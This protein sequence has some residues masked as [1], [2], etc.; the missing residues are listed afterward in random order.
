MNKDNKHKELNVY[1]EEITI[2]KMIIDI[3]ILILFIFLILTSENGVSSFE[4]FKN[5]LDKACHIFKLK[6]C[7][8]TLSIVSLIAVMSPKFVFILRR[9][10]KGSI[11]VSIQKKN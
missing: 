2:A 9:F 8:T 5:I 10:E 11:I 7:I 4:A 6:I 1:S 3:E